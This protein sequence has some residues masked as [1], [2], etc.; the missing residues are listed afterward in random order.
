M[1][2]AKLYDT[3]VSPNKRTTMPRFSGNEASGVTQSVVNFGSSLA[4]LGETVYLKNKQD[5]EQDY[6]SVSNSNM[7]QTMDSLWFDGK[8]LDVGQSPKGMSDR[9]W[10][11]SHTFTVEEN[12]VEVQKKFTYDEYVQYNMGL[13]ETEEGKRAVELAGQIY[14]E[15]MIKKTRAWEVLQVAAYNQRNRDEF[16]SGVSQEIILNPTSD[17]RWTTIVAQVD[18]QIL[19]W[20]NRAG[21][22]TKVQTEQRDKI[23]GSLA[24]S[25]VEELLKDDEVGVPLLREL[26]Y[27]KKLPEWLSYLSESQRV[28]ARAAVEEKVKAMDSLLVYKTGVAAETYITDV[29]HGNK[30][31]DLEVMRENVLANTCYEPPCNVELAKF[32]TKYNNAMGEKSL[33]NSIFGH[34]GSTNVVSTEGF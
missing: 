33:R 11:K 3:Q 2:Q 1:A 10:S 32:D 9:F 28:A 31:E 13:Y 17:E 7:R 25:R 20:S 16:L 23:L 6:T 30:V 27:K 22:S 24:V 14:K 29:L 8:N 26:L 15:E 18:Q 4:K 34:D 19:N 21:W 12:G 5:E